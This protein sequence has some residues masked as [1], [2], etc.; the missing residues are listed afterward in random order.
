[1]TLMTCHDCLINFSRPRKIAKNDTANMYVNWYDFFVHK[2]DEKEKSQGFNIKYDF[3]LS[4]FISGNLKIGNKYR[5]KKR[6]YNRH[7]EYGR[8]GVPGAV[9]IARQ[10]LMNRY[11]L[12][13][14]FL[15][16]N[17]LPLIPFIDNDYDDGGGGI[18]RRR[19]QVQEE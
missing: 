6:T 15:D 2:S 5:T 12:G 9:S 8:V 1:M 4:N 7:H 17:K 14:S 11:D 13:D 18:W 16:A 10:A 3:R 19:N